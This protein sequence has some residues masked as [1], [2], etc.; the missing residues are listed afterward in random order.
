MSRKQ[1]LAAKARWEAMTEEQRVEWARRQ[2][3]GMRQHWRMKTF[4][5]KRAI[6]LKRLKTMAE[7]R[8]RGNNEN[9]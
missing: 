3:E 6:T 7:N 8:K 1:V 5:E 2:V 4:E 9:D